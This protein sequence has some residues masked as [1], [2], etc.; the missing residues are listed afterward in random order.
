MNVHD[1]E[2]VSNLLYHDGYVATHELD[3]AD[4]LIINTCSIR[5]K[6]EHRL[7][8]DLGALRE[9]KD[10]SAERVLGVA[11]CVAQ[12]QGDALLR[13]F[14]HVDFVFGPQ[15]VHWVPTMVSAATAGRR[16]TLVEESR[17]LERFDLPE[18]HPEYDGAA[19][20]RAY[21][22]VMEGCDM[23]CAFCIVPQT[24]GREVSR[25]ADAIVSEVE[26]LAAR[27]VLE[28]TL[29]G[30]TVNAYGRHDAR[31]NRERA[32]RAANVRS[33]NQGDAVGFA[34]LL[35]RLSE[36]PGIRRLRYTSPHPLFFDD[37]LIRAHGEIPALCPHIHL[38]VQSG[39][40]AVLAR[41]RRRY[42]ADEYRRLAAALRESR[43]G[44]SLSTDLIVGFPGETDADF[45]AT[46]ALVRDVEFVDSFSFKYSPRPNTAA[47]EMDGV[48]PPDVAQ[49]RLEEIQT[50]QRSLTLSAHRARVG[51]T[52][53][54]LI[55]G[56]SRLGGSQHC[57]RDPG[58]RVVNV[59]LP[60]GRAPSPGTLI[61]VQIVEATPHSLIGEWHGAV[62]ELPA[63]EPSE[64]D[65]S[66]PLK[67]PGRS[68]D[69]QGRSA[70]CA[71]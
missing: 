24:R 34:G 60:D 45:Q 10:G 69:E 70:P 67:G 53:E 63:R 57:G 12:Q 15:N 7:Y 26:A 3:Q 42:T 43:P 58:H 47:L 38:P 51:E 59:N 11:G 65:E 48:V 30:Q 50:L 2:K 9:W 55:A 33:A 19:P 54:I 31:R 16:S 14:T 66:A 6:A 61:E 39:S 22:T 21:V 62:A 41:M 18:R 44:L 5:E 25:P 17:S 1:S 68:A 20:G 71:G 64:G 4:L 56:P 8:S 36:I 13:R 23:F 35:Q 29:L 32:Q 52:T 46:L 27:G 49:A 28:V 40:D 37:S